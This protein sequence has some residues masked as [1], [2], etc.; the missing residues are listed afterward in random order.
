[1]NTCIIYVM[2]VS[3]CGKTTIGKKLSQRIHIPFFDGD[4]FHSEANKE[5]MKSGHPLTNQDRTGWLLRLNELAKEQAKK[6]GAII[7]CSALKEEYRIVLSDEISV[8]IYWIFLQGSYDLIKK[9]MEMRKGHYMAA[10]MLR[11]QFDSLEIPKYAITIDISTSLDDIV[12]QITQ[13][14]GIKKST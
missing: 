12:T 8:P 9:R 4:D 10:S 1:M 5:K 2:G 13:D 11:S 3:G 7:A 14:I 6:K